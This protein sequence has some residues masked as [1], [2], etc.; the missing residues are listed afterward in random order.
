MVRFHAWVLSVICRLGPVRGILGLLITYDGLFQLITSVGL[1][2]HFL[3]HFCQRSKKLTNLAGLSVFSYKTIIL[4]LKE[5]RV[6]GLTHLTHPLDYLF[7]GILKLIKDF[8]SYTQLCI[9]CL[10]HVPCHGWILGYGSIEGS[11]TICSSTVP[12]KHGG[13][14]IQVSLWNF[15]SC[16][17]C[18]FPAILLQ[19][20]R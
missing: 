4:S 14:K 20:S 7:T 2:Q 5:V 18:L 6:R 1:F 9:V 3:Q 19:W 16:W 11:N 13:N 15:Q 12:T 10:F 17:Y 8:N